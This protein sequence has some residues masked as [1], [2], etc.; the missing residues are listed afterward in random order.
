MLSNVHRVRVGPVLSQGR[1]GVAPWWQEHLEPCCCALS[2]G[3]CLA[4]SALTSWLGWHRQRFST[5]TLLF[6]SLWLVSILGEIL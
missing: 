6:F 4:R 2:R 5:V 3:S 1:S